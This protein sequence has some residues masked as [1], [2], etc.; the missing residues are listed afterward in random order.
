M[1]DIVSKRPH[2]MPSALTPED[3]RAFRKELA[4]LGVPVGAEVE[5]PPPEPLKPFV[6]TR[7]PRQWPWFALQI[8]TFFGV[9]I[10]ITVYFD[11][12]H[13]KGEAGMLLGAAAA[14][15]VTCLI[16]SL[17][18][19]LAM[20]RMVI[21]NPSHSEEPGSQER[22]LLSPSRPTSDG[23]QQIPGSGVGQD[24]RELP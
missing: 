20:R 19:L 15:G 1:R 22:E 7:R 11:F 5:P 16:G 9:W 10:G 24:R 18:C 21:T 3:D 2:Q 17:Q 14:F 12:D 4:R 23:T 6:F 8:A 13:K